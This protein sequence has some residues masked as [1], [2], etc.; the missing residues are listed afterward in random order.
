MTTDPRTTDR[1]WFTPELITAAEWG[2]YLFRF[3]VGDQPLEQGGTIRVQLPDSWHAW[4]R[5]GAKG[6]QSHEPAADN[7]VTGRV[8]SGSASVRCEV[9]GGVAE[10]VV[11][12]N[13]T[14]IDGRAGRYVYVTR[15]TVV[16]GRLAP[17]DLVEIRFGDVSGGSRGFAA[18]LHPEGPEQV[19]VAVDPDGSGYARILLAEQSPVLEV[20]PCAPAELLCYGPSLLGAGESGRIRV[21]VVDAEGNRVNSI[22]GLPVPRVRDG[23][24]L[25]EDP[26]PGELGGT[27]E[28]GFTARS[29]GVVRVSVYLPALPA[30]LTNPCWVS[31]AAPR[32]R[33]YW[34]DLHSHSD[35]SFDGVGHFPYEYARDV[36]CLDFYAL[37]EHCE[38]W[39]EGDWEN[40]CE[41]VAKYHD[42]GRFVTFLAYEATFHEPWGHHNVYF[43]DPAD[44]LV[45]GAD[46]GTVLDLWRALKG[47]RAL[48]IPHHTGVAF[49]PKTAGSIPGST[50]PAVDWQYHQPDLRRTVEIYSGHGQS[51][52]YDPSF[53]LSY[54]NSDFSTN[55]SRNGP[56]YAR[57][58]WELGHQLGVI[59]SSDNHR[60][61]PGRGELGLAA[62]FAPELERGAVFDALHD[63]QS[64]GTT[65]ARMLLD[66]SVNGTPMGQS[67]TAEGPL[68]FEI[69]VAGTEELDTVQILSGRV[70]ASE[71]TKVVAAW[72]PTG[73]DFS[74]TWSAA[75]PAERTFYYLRVRQRTSYR[76]R[77]A[78]AWS[79]PI[80]IEP[81]RD[82]TD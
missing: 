48:T 41:R 73:L 16:S 45:L 18:A 37:T 58:A 79:S 43:R 67:S 80:W 15:L 44:A 40:L 11:K 12:S 27:F 75:A 68:R 1:A 29:P 78:T 47:R 64:Y 55:T 20:Q 31:P 60:A 51:E 19:L 39:R 6:V 23:D 36:S 42:P 62:V 81:G 52:F 34:G 66:F 56:H 5:N 59:G 70:G 69:R 65:G 25:L 7:H 24:V 13:R 46:Q 32:Q 21:V 54:E 4:R 22:G 9:E 38:R 71:S 35:H 3:R 2:S 63:R 28:I 77:K 14:G 53:D 61:Q 10:D 33:L 8:A 72:L 76:G 74:G 26:V 57:D 30:G 17:G 82:G 49:S 50:S